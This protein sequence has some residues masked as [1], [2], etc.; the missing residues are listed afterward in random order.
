MSR[1][2]T[3]E[4]SKTLPPLY[5]TEQVAD[6]VVFV[7][8]FTPDSSWTWYCLEYDPAERLCFGLVVGHERELGYFSL[9]ELEEVRGPL[10]LPIERDHY[11]EPK[12]LSQCP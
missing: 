8:F 6:P 2:L 11:W 1:L 7:K 12:P 10:E 9:D 5:S 3:D 4:V